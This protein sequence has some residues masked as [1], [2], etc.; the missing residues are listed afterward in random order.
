MTDA[1]NLFTSSIEPIS[2]KTEM[3]RSYLD[4][5]MSVIVSRALPDVRDGLKPVHRRI[6]FTMHEM[7]L[8]HNRSFR[9]CAR[10]VGDVMGKYHPHGNMAIYDALVRMAQDFSMRETLIWG[11]GNF[12]SMDGDSPA[13]DRYTEAKL[14][15]ISDFLLN[16]IDSDTVD[17]RPN[18]D[19][20]EQEPKVLPARFPNLLVNGAAGIAVGM[21]TNIPPHNLGEVIDATLMLVDN[22]TATIE[23]INQH[24]L[25]PD[26]PTGGT[27]MGRKGI[28]T[29]NAMGRGSVIVRGKTEIEKLRENK[30]AIIIN[31]MPYQVNKAKL[32]ERIA[33]LVKEKIVEDISDLRDESDRDGVRVVIELKR[34]AVAEVV[35]NQ[36]YKHTPLQTSF[37]YNM[38]ALD[39]DRPKLMGVKEILHCFLAH[40]EE[41]ITRRTRFELNKARDRAHILVGLAIAV[42]NIDE[43]IKII[44]NAP[45]PQVARDQMMAKPWKAESVVALVELLGETMAEQ[46]TY[47]LS[48]KQAQAI[49]DLRLH[50]LTGLERDKINDEAAE[51]QKTIQFLVDILSNRAVMLKVLKDELIEVK[52]Q[53]ATPRRTVITDG[54]ADVDIADLITPEDVVVTISTDGY[55]KRQPIAAFR[56]Q[57]R[58]GKGKAVTNLKDDEQMAQM[59]VAN[60]HDTVLFFSSKGQV[61]QLKI[62]ELPTASA[63]SRGKA[64][65]NL[66]PLQKEEAINS[67][68]PIP[69]N[70]AEWGEQTIMFATR[71]GMIRRTPLIAFANVRAAGIHGMGLNEG[72]ELVTAQL[73]PYTKGDVLLSTAHGQA[74]R[75]DLT[76]LRPIASRT[77]YGVKGMNLRKGD[78]VMSMSVI[79]PVEAE[80]QTSHV[81]SV[82][83]RGYGKLSPVADYPAKGRGTLGVISIKTTTRNGEVVSV[84]PVNLD[85]QLMFA[86]GDGQIMRTRVAD[87]SVMGRNTQGVKLFDVGA[88]GTVSLVVRIPA[89]MLEDKNSTEGLTA[90]AEQATP[91]MLAEAA[92]GLNDATDDEPAADTPEDDVTIH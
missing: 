12:G 83:A 84:I 43:I 41:V 80:L 26:F 37:S 33:E 73:C 15:K 16:D 23:E 22:P 58:G 92:S 1:N 29:G 24:I 81:L 45:D 85:D 64:F 52:N 89:D 91:D 87:I 74:L 10:I 86:T 40:R 38:L 18:Y 27:I 31:E 56:A 42:A 32:V 2:I 68:V 6:L 57:R 60:T 49:L 47:S 44:R 61:Y 36:L 88:K 66:L 14:T 78:S 17:F 70:Q 63:Q 90:P 21:A 79:A 51:I 62:Y 67:V 13:A 8:H 28:L 34:G 54:G 35:L 30:E 76:L 69:A 55:V 48:A 82:T 25:G 65:V 50:R 4:Y 75:F 46:K 9:K 3:E 39:R 19:G 59:F 77:A 11:Q 72:D 7:S 71:M 5:A 53:F 20:H